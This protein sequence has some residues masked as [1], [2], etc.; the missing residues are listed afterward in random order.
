MDNCPSK[1]LSKIVSPLSICC[2]LLSGAGQRYVYEIDIKPHICSGDISV[3][4]CHCQL[5]S[6]KCEG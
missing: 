2:L 4:S 6:D 3:K 5:Y 1:M